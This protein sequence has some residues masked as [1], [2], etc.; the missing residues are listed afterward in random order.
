METLNDQIQEYRHQLQNKRIQKAYLGIM[1]F[2]SGLSSY[3]AGWHTNYLVSGMYFGYMD[4]TYFA[5]TPAKLKN[6]KLKIAIVYLHEE[7]R[8]ELWLSGSN[9]RIQAE[10]IERLRKKAIGNYKLSS[11][12]PG[13]DSIIETILIEN[14]DF[15]HQEELMRQ[16]EEKTLKFISDMSGLIETG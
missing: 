8:F 9:R 5:F 3:L 7:G 16:I 2:M 6:L 15:D 11:L 14:P 4:M 10:Y 13:V 1:N 12:H